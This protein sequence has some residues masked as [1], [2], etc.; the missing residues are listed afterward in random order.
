MRDREE[1]MIHS[2]MRDSTRLYG[3]Q[4]LQQSYHGMVVRVIAVSLIEHWRIRSV[5]AV[6]FSPS[7]FV[8]KVVPSPIDGLRMIVDPSSFRSGQSGYGSTIVE[9]WIPILSNAELNFQFPPTTSRIVP[10]FH[11]VLPKVLT[12]HLAKC[13]CLVI[14]SCKSHCCIV[15]ISS[16]SAE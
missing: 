3:H 15:N 10:W 14:H 1:A 8:A 9:F 12:N 6:S 4:K 7:W 13:S 16:S 5:R 2:S 11:I